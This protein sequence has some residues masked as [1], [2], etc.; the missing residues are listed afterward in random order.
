VPASVLATLGAIEFKNFGVV[1]VTGHNRV[2]WGW[3]ADAVGQGDLF[4]V[5]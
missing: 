1:G 5:R 3:F 2:G 4:T